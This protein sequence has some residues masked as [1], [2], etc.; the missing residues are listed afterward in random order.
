AVSLEELHL[1]VNAVAAPVLDQKAE[2]IGAIGIA[3]P[4]FRLTP[5]KLH[6]LGR[7]VIEAANRISGNVGEIAMSI[8]VTPR[9]ATGPTPGLTPV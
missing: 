4:A 9:P 6:A 7:E 5:E 1:G 8:S 2:P 3:G